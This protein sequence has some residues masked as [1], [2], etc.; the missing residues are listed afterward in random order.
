MKIE[1]A[2]IQWLKDDS[3][4]AAHAREKAQGDEFEWGDSEMH[5]LLIDVYGSAQ[6]AADLGVDMGVRSEFRK[7]NGP[8]PLIEMDR[9]PVR[10]FLVGGEE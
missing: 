2:V 1:D 5:E 4:L 6:Y 8:M 7:T 3:Q 9:T 10:K